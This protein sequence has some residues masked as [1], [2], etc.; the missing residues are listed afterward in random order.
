MIN[1]YKKQIKTNKKRSD[2]PSERK[3]NCFSVLFFFER[4]KVARR[5]L[6]PRA[7][8]VV[9]KRFALINVAAD[10]ADEARLFFRL[11]RRFDVRLI[12]GVRDRL[13]VA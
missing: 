1:F 12:I 13:V 5:V 3:K 11:G 7:D 2:K 8:K 10:G 4:D 6:A 9:G